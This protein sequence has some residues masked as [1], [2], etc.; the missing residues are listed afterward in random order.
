MREIGCTNHLG[1]LFADVDGRLQHLQLGTVLDGCLHAGI[2]GRKAG[3][4][5]FLIFVGQGDFAFDGKSAELAE[6]HFRKHQSVLGLCEFHLGL[7]DLHLHLQSVGLCGYS[8]GNHLLH[9]V[10]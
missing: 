4:D 1:G 10:I 5:V 7:V 2:V 8:L 3:K 6:Q 9:V